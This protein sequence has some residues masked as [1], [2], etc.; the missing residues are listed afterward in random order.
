MSVAYNALGQPTSVTH[1]D[2]TVEKATYDRA[3]VRTGVVHWVDQ[4][5][6]V[7]ERIAQETTRLL[8]PTV[9][10]MLGK[11][12]RVAF[13]R[14]LSVDRDSIWIRQRHLPRAELASARVASGFIDL[15]RR[16]Q[17]QPWARV[18]LASVP[19]PFVFLHIVSHRDP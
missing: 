14:W 7:G 13:G 19:N 6:K 12:A 16:G 3:R 11:G 15:L 10:E 5:E 8:L 9:Y 18:R 4:I 17:K 2:G 1:P